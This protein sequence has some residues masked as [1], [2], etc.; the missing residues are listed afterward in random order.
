MDAQTAM[1]LF[2]K[3]LLTYNPHGSDHDMFYYSLPYERNYELTNSIPIAPYSGNIIKYYQYQLKK[4]VIIFTDV[5]DTEAEEIEDTEDIDEEL[6]AEGD[7]FSDE[8]YDG[9]A[10]DFEGERELSEDEMAALLTEDSGDDEE[11]YE[12]APNTGAAETWEAPEF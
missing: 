9:E 6:M 10:E 8:E 3:E 12:K 2:S 5:V 7:E 11:V 4:P 1:E